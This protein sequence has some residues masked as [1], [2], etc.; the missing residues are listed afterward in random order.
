MNR[1]VPYL[2]IYLFQITVLHKQARHGTISINFHVST[3]ITEWA[4]VA[5]RP[6]TAHIARAAAGA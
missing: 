6:A 2:I 3:L 1:C 5:E 4:C